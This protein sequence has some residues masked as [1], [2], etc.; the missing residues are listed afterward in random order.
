MSKITDLLSKDM[1][2]AQLR[3][4][5]M[6]LAKAQGWDV[7]YLRDSRMATSPGFPDLCL[8]RG[9][10]RPR[11]V[12]AELKTLKGRI[13]KPQELWLAGLEATPEVHVWRPT[14]WYDS[15]ISE[16]LA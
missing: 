15:T 6:A 8:R 5:T 11:I 13:S 1:T 4:L 16:V 12:Y 3:G 14:D 7:Y 2:E 9:G 10:D